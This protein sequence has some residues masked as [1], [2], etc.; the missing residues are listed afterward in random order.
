[1][2]NNNNNNNNIIRVYTFTWHLNV[3]LAAIHNFS[4]VHIQI[5]FEWKIIFINL[6]WM[7]IFIF[8][9]S[10]QCIFLNVYPFDYCVKAIRIIKNIS[11]KICLFY[12][13]IILF[14]QVHTYISINIV[15]TCKV[16]RLLF[17]V[18]TVYDLV[19]NVSCGGYILRI[20][21][22]NINCF[23]SVRQAGLESI[24]LE[25]VSSFSWEASRLWSFSA[26]CSYVILHGSFEVVPEQ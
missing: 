10:E 11:Q 1:M 14:I 9:I 13:N 8:L 5:Y 26:Y 16:N 23:Q 21:I 18:K 22:F 17:S 15:Y 24:I 20:C 4:H 7:E 2:C 25:S 19:I 12:K 3:Q 6:L